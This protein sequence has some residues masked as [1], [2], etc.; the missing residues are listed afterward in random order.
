MKMR[1]NSS[2]W[3]IWL[4]IFLGGAYASN[5]QPP[6]SLWSR[7]FGVPGILHDEICNAVWQTSDDG[8]V[9]AGY[10]NSFGAGSYDFW[11]VKTDA[12]GDS[13]WSRTFGGAG[14]DLCY[15]MQQTADGGYFLAGTTNSFGVGRHDFWLMKTD[16]NGDSLWSRT[17]G[18]DLDDQCWAA[19]QTS[20]GG[21]ILA[22]PW[23]ATALACDIG[24][25]KTD[26]NGESE[27][28][29]IIGG[30]EY[31][32]CRSVEQ[33]SDGGYILGGYRSTP[34]LT[35]E[36]LLIKTDADG[37][38]LWSRTYGWNELSTLCNVVC[39]TSD[40]GYILA[41]KLSFFN[42][43]RGYGFLLRTDASGDSL[44]SRLFGRGGGFGGD[45]FNAVLLSPDGGF[46]A[47]GF[48]EG[49]IQASGD[50]W[51]VRTNASGDSL[52]SRTFAKDD[53]QYGLYGEVC[54]S[55]QR[56]SDG[57]YILAGFWGQGDFVSQP[58]FWLVKT[59]PESA[60]DDLPLSR[61]FLPRLSLYP[62]PF[63]PRTTVSFSLPRTSEIELG[64]YDVLG[65]KVSQ[66]AK[67]WFLPGKHTL[68]FDGRG[69]PSGTYFVRLEASGDA[70]TQKLL[71]VK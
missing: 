9:L 43:F 68:Y 36:I 41:G 4:L 45:E 26:E 19:K 38:T 21:Y 35:W 24:L 16:A 56:T 66:L 52:W 54:T 67:G 13:L 69:L 55:L 27:W 23:N 39:Q 8:Y 29:Q 20:D 62:N 33:T 51:L 63:N 40:G 53:P 49:D 1:R 3:L 17:F 22:G 47:A 58:D 50:Y 28:I 11:L 71:L 44:W 32:I 14:T 12:Q 5:A 57:G 70:T 6:D 46:V 61:P 65:R 18:G 42:P 15:A 7:T 31:E 30:P 64:V 59:G 34:F 10:T 37:D 25:V 2:F 60:A 48:L